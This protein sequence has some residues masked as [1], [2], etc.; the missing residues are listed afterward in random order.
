MSIFKKHKNAFAFLLL[1]CDF[2][3]NIFAQAKQNDCCTARIDSMLRILP[4]QREDS[5]RVRTL[6][7][8]AWDKFNLSWS[9]GGDYSGAIDYAHQGMALAE[10]IKFKWGKGRANFILGKCFEEKADYAESL[11]Y[12]LAG[13]KIA[14]EN[15]N[16]ILA[17]NEYYI[18]G[19][20]Y[21]RMANYPEAFKN[22][23]AA[24]EIA[25]EIKA[26]EWYADL[27]AT[28][29]T[30]YFSTGILDQAEQHYN[31]AWDIAEKGNEITM[32]IDIRT[33]RGDLALSK[34]SYEEALQYFYSNLKALE[35]RPN[36]SRIAN[37]YYNIASTYLIKDS[38]THD[39][40]LII[41]NSE[42]AISYL[43]KSLS[44]FNEIGVKES[45]IRVYSV[46]D[47]AYRVIHDYKN[48]LYYADL[49]KQSHDSV[50][51]KQAY[52][53][54]AEMKVQYETEKAAAAFKLEQ[55]KLRAEKQEMNNL[56]LTTLIFVVMTSLFAFFYSRQRTA[57]IRA[58]EKAESIRK[59]S[60]LEMQSLR[61]QLNPHFMF[62]S[63]N[64]IQT[65]IM[66][67]E[68]DKSQTY[69]S[70]FARLLRI[71][72]ENT[73]SPFIPLQKEIDFLQ[74][75][76]SLESLRIPDMQYSISID[77]LLNT[78][79]ILIPNMLLQPYAENAIWHG[80][81]HKVKDKQLQIRVSREN[82]SVNY[83]IEDNGVG[84]KKAKEL[85]SFFNK[86]H[87]S[88]GMELVQKRISLLSKEYNSAIITE[89]S[90]VIKNNEVAGTLVS[91]K[92]PDMV[93]QPT[94]G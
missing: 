32:M 16:R 34:G 59:I 31:K 5:S 26:E 87:Q 92:I 70:R 22:L 58:V 64:S 6:L 52:V 82:D 44:I 53:K 88:K 17:L 40:G 90:D 43:H 57:K 60:E 74:L 19:R 30:I 9:V 78:E 25:K 69:L 7:A 29:G 45:I 75:Y 47:K 66:K 85:E 77:P 37:T 55:E 8:I 68:N 80:L 23:F 56:L 93:S 54:M 81:S 73:E 1:F 24:F 2:N 13:L 12:C 33:Y 48:A 50:F 89:I 41:R 72:L 49:Y 11:K 36:K 84:R 42:K 15:G 14:L 51:S 83:E 94:Q 39:T 91:I 71:M 28:I 86:Q 3:L 63:L 21:R 46:L 76:L 38:A 61:S 27:Y 65:L 67:Q 20:N 35:K 79:K 18:I 10:K 4:Q 62:N